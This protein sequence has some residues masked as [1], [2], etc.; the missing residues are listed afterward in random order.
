MFS[1]KKLTVSGPNKR[2]S[3]IIFGNRL[4]IIQGPSNTGKTTILKCIEYLLGG[5]ETPIS[6]KHG[7]DTLSLEIEKNNCC[8]TFGMDD[9]LYRPQY[10][11][12]YNAL[13]QCKYNCQYKYIYI[14]ICACDGVCRYVCKSWIGC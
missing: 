11:G 3:E 6:D 13:Y 12:H 4:T 9:P 1:I 14:C 2:D 8:I 5:N 7:Y 10:H